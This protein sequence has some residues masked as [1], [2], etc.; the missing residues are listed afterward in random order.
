MIV[1]LHPQTGSGNL[2]SS[3]LF[4]TCQIIMR[5]PSNGNPL[6]DV[7][8]SEHDAQLRAA[9]ACY[10]LCSKIFLSPVAG[11]NKLFVVLFCRRFLWIFNVR[12]LW[13]DG[14]RYDRNYRSID[15]QFRWL[16]DSNPA[17]TPILWDLFPLADAPRKY[18]YISGVI[19]TSEAKQLNSPVV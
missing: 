6:L 13:L 12:F 9:D 5:F 1:D 10:L 17:H 3:K 4:M 15:W 2:P 18:I 19:T 8:L 16:V 11:G 7:A 14:K